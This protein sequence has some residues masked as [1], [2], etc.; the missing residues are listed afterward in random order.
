MDTAIP[1]PGA[2]PVARLPTVRDVETIAAIDDP[3]LRNVR[4]THTYHLLA[5]AFAAAAGPGANWCTFAVW[6]SRQAGQTIRGE[7]ALQAMESALRTRPEVEAALDGMFRRLVR[8]AFGRPGSKRKEVLRILGVDAFH[9]ASA[10]IAAGNLKVFAEIGR[11]FARFLPLC[12]GGRVDPQAL[13]AFLA[14]L[15]P[16]DPP[17]GQDYLR[18][19]F[20]HY[21]QAMETADARERAELLHLANL[22]IGMHEQTRLQPEI[23]AALEV[24]FETATGLGRRILLVLAPGSAGWWGWASTAAAAGIGAFGKL[25]ERSIRALLR[26]AVTGALMTLRLPDGALR[27]GRHL[28]EE[29]PESLREPRHPELVAMLA[30]FRP[31]PGD[32][33]GTGADDWSVLEERMLLIGALFRCRHQ[34]RALFGA[35]FTPAQVREAEAGR[36]PGG[37]L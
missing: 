33:N 14:G 5:S 21:A 20:A 36:V 15:R 7:D 8:E 13:A 30:R 9:R 22:E 27:L 1:L 18:R 35:P 17:E 6:A 11:E 34:D 4:I 3:C 16:G 29:P 37:V 32:A 24:P 28:G 10:A 25:S 19:A 12:E 2:F 26:H 23:L 31:A